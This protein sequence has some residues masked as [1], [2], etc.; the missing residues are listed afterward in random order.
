[1]PLE[2]DCVDARSGI[3]YLQQGVLILDFPEEDASETPSMACALTQC[4]SHT[5]QLILVLDTHP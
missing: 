5:A 2:Y 4:H 3:R 1:M